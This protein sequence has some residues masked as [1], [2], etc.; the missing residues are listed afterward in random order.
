MI[1]EI[2]YDPGSQLWPFA[3]RIGCRY[4]MLE[5]YYRQTMKKH[6]YGLRL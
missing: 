5:L 3:C 6:L 4:F 1:L 2:G